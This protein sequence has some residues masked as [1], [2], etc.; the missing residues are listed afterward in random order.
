MAEAWDLFPTNFGD[1]FPQLGDLFPQKKTQKEHGDLL[2][3]LEH[4]IIECIIMKLV[5][6]IS[7]FTGISFTRYSS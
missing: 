3:T 7:L 1:L 4:E 2:F 6:E 5:M